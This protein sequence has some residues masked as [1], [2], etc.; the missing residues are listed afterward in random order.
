MKRLFSKLILL[1]CLVCCFLFIFYAL[2]AFAEVNSSDIAPEIFTAI[3]KTGKYSAK[4]G[5]IL[6]DSVAQQL[7]RID[8]DSEDYCHLACNQGIT[9]C[10]NY[11]L[12][13]EYLKNNPQ[14][15]SVIYAVRPQS[16]SNDF[17]TDFTYQY[18]VLPFCSRNNLNL[19]KDSSISKLESV[20]GK[21]FIHSRVL[22]SA[23][24][25]NTAFLNIYLHN[26]QSDEPAVY[27]RLSEVSAT[28]IRLMNDYCKD[29][30]IVFRVVSCPLRDSE[31]NHDW[32]LFLQDIE[33]MGMEDLLGDY[34]PGIVYYPDECF[35]SD[36]VHLDLKNIPLSLEELRSVVLG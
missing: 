14:T 16:L 22:R 8:E 27:N 24:L 21:P 19:I 5:V 12:L 33:G 31:E 2:L 7:W 36:K 13:V 15:E 25:N 35:L 11:L 26:L 6:G 3:E 29:R 10:G 17:R 20:F 9:A 4:N 18:F 30:K 1:F 34:I 28:Y 23:M 32:N